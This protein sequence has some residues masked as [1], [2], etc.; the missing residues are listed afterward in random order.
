MSTHTIDVLDYSPENDALLEA[1]S[2]R[3]V[4]EASDTGEPTR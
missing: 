3:A 1:V 2:R 4:R